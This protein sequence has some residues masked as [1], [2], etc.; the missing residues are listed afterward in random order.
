MP[1]IKELKFF[2]TRNIEG[3]DIFEVCL[4]LKHLSLKKGEYV[5]KYGDIGDSFYIILSGLV[6]IRIPDWKAK[7]EVD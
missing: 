5:F 6:S 3:T 2:K 4:E 7:A 1:L